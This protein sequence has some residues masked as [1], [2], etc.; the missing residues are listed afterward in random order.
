MKRYGRVVKLAVMFMCLF[1]SGV[2]AKGMF[3]YIY[4]SENFK[5][6]KFDRSYVPDEYQLSAVKFILK[7]TFENNIHKMRGETGNK[8]FISKEKVEGGYAEAVYDKNGDLVKND[9]NMGSYNYFHVEEEP[10]M[11]F[12]ADTLP[13]LE[14]GNTSKD[15]TNF[16]ERL[17][18]Y[19][20]DLDRGIQAY[21]FRAKDKELEKVDFKK[22]SKAEKLTYQFFS[23][24]I[25]NPEYKVKLNEVNRPKLKADGKYYKSYFI[26]I[27]KLLGVYQGDK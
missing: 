14:F 10:I 11:H 12:V 5:K 1:V 26:Q 23:H 13:W 18:Y 4:N 9:Y 24:I 19:T 15:P 7:N 21:I 16:K 25:F 3:A 2:Y 20:Y 8:T 17:F 27:Q 6:I 22:L